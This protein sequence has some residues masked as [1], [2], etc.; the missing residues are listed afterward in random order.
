MLIITFFPF[1]CLWMCAILDL[2]FNVNSDPLS[3]NIWLI[4]SMINRNQRIKYAEK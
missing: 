3:N 2:I 4:D 1:V